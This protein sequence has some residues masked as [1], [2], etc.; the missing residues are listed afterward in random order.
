MRTALDLRSDVANPTMFPAAAPLVKDFRSDVNPFFT[1]LLYSF[2]VHS[3]IA[4]I[5][6]AIALTVVVVLMVRPRFGVLFLLCTIVLSPDRVISEVTTGRIIIENSIF[7]NMFGG[8]TLST[9]VVVACAVVAAILS[10]A[11]RIRP[12]Y[13]RM[14][15]PLFLPLFVPLHGLVHTDEIRVF[16]SDVRY[17][18]APL[19]TYALLLASNTSPYEVIRIFGLSLLAKCVTVIV[20][21]FW[22]SGL[23]LIFW[24]FVVYLV[25]TLVFLQAR[26]SVRFQLMTAPCIL[27][28]ILFFP[29]RGRVLVFLFC[30]AASFYRG[31]WKHRAILGFISALMFLVLILPLLRQETL[32]ARHFLYKIRTVNAFDEDNQSANVRLVEFVNIVQGA[33]HKWYPLLIGEGY[34]GSFTDEYYPFDIRSLLASGAAFKE[35]QIL[36]G[37]FYDTH[38]NLN[39]MMLKAGPLW[40]FAFFIALTYFGIMRKYPV[41]SEYGLLM[42]FLP[43]LG[44]IMVTIKISLLFGYFAFLLRCALQ[45]SDGFSES[46]VAHVPN[47]TAA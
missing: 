32:V 15:W 36:R 3:D 8:F 39:F 4:V 11:M 40:T 14:F 35:E 38:T 29:G 25:P 42:F 10:Y 43:V 19:P 27:C 33:F 24:G 44:F 30:V 13:S 17:L 2:V 45:L 46:S 6:Y 5:A 23:T 47:P 20:I 12:A 34:G 7:L 37:E 18:L 26:S 22:S 16:V 21:S 31:N 41:P 1:I 28:P 9:F